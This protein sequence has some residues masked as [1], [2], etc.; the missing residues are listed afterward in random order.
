MIWIST[1]TAPDPSARSRRLRGFSLVEVLVSLAISTIAIA[2]LVRATGTAVR[3]A[4]TSEVYNTAILLAETKLGEV[5]SD[6][7]SFYADEEGEFD[8]PHEDFTWN[9]SASES[10]DIAG[11][12]TVAVEINWS[13][14]GA[15]AITTFIYEAA[16]YVETELEL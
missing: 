16:L 13:H 6:G 10:A 14:G 12:Y 3:A 2:A 4:I 1:K 7:V 15:Y 5:R 11:L 9:V 8:P